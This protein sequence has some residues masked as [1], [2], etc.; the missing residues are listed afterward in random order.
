MKCA[1]RRWRLTDAKELAAALNNRKILNN[2]RDG[3]PFPYTERDARDYIIA[4]L[5]A[6]EQETFAY[7]ITRMT[8]SSAASAPSARGISTGRRGSWVTIW[9]RSTGGRAS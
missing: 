4:T 9:R 3:L 7:A 6:N 8:M 1:L 5:S 2:L